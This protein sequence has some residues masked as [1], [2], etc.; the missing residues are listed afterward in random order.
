MMNLRATICTFLL[1]IFSKTNSTSLH[2]TPADKDNNVSK[3]SLLKDRIESKGIFKGIIILAEF[4]DTPF[5]L[6]DAS[7]LFCK[8]L[9]SNH[10]D[11]QGAHGSVRDYFINNS[12]SLFLPTFDVVGPFKL[13]HTMD[14]YGRNDENG[15]EP[16]AGEMIMDACKE[17]ATVINYS[18]Y[19]N[20]NDGTVDM[21]Y[22]IFASYGENENTSNKDYIWAHSGDIADSC[23]VI[24]GKRIARYA[25]SSEY[26]G[27]ADNPDP[28]M[29]TIGTF[30]H[31]F[32]H[33]LGLP[34]FYNTMSGS[35]MTPGSMS[36][37]D[38]G[39]Y[40]DDGKCPAGYS[41]FEKEYVNWINIPTI[42][43][44][45]TTL[46][47]IL[48]PVNSDIK[49]NVTC[50]VKI[51]IDS[52]EYYYLENRQNESWDKYLPGTGLFIYH[53]DLSDSTAW[54]ENR[55]NTNFSHPNYDLIRSN[56]KYELDYQK[57]SFPGKA[58]KTTFI[59]PQSWKEENTDFKIEN[60]RIFERYVAFDYVNSKP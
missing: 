33:L 7:D 29:A 41:S 38:K 10:Y 2:I 52:C 6:P 58:C 55:V 54:D 16:H 56:S 1:L 57:I 60:I 30:C 44:T 31:E 27:K 17:A 37:M 47:I 20:N 23:L 28:Q 43:A 59:P 15:E 25:C 5:T 22:I 19:D 50:A 45:D 24:D 8:M 42:S 14:Y 46:Q 12:D 34:D 21:V 53:V 9:N 11:R 39:N 51:Q 18:D 3:N 32:S 40:L 4:A 26:Q 13:P 48:S 35:G 36:L 49:S